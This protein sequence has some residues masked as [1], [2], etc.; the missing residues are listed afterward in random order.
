MRFCPETSAE[1][2]TE[3]NDGSKMAAISS[4]EDQCVLRNGV[5]PGSAPKRHRT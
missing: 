5:W 4:F 2:T 3:S 1:T